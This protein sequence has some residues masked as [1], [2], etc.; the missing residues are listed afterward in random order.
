VTVTGA[1]AEYAVPTA[2]SGLSGI[3]TGPDGAIWF[4][5]RNVNKIGQLK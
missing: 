3:T 4:T 1:F 2:A 5:E